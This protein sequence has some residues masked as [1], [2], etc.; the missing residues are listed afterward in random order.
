MPNNR[1][2]Y[3]THS[4]AIKP[5]S[6]ALTFTTG[7]LAHGVQSVGINSNFN[8]T[9][10]FGLGNISIYENVEGIPE[11]E[12]T[13]QKVSDGRPPLLTLAT[14][15]A[16]SPTLA[17]RSASRCDIG[18]AVYPDTNTY[19]SGTPNSVCV[20]SGMYWNSSSFSFNAD[21]SPFLEDASFV[22]N[23]K[24]WTR[25]PGFATG[26]PSYGEPDLGTMPTITW[27]AHMAASVSPLAIGG[28]DASQEFKFDLPTATGTLS[29]DENGA[30][31]HPDV[32]VFP[33]EIEGITVSGTNPMS[34][35]G[36]SRA[37]HVSTV[38]VN[39]SFNR[40]SINELGRRGPYSRTI[41]F[42]V[43]VTSEFTNTSAQGD[44]VSHTEQGIFGTGVGQ[45]SSDRT[46][47]RHRT[48]RIATCAGLR[49]Y[50]GRRNKL[51][52]VSYAGGDAGG[53]N[54]TTTYSYT[55]QNDYTVM[56]E[57]DPHP[58]GAAWWAARE[59]NGYL[60]E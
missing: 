59:S 19:A 17:G 34:S 5:N 42:P 12:I 15:A 27:N 3:A 11:V 50:L 26:T 51:A 1:I 44:L 43:E 58:S 28:I 35:D 45:C 37:A 13:M 20:G 29:A 46:N 41:A 54:V 30:V 14:T 4:V 53:G 49:I 55:T 18:L 39:V 52:S 40:E 7:H 6:G 9:P 23:D 33:T 48:I 2:F 38:S 10:I 21:G 16:A 47:L 24:I 31:N 8:L 36:I 22:G 25:A 60:I 32:S 56:H 57:N